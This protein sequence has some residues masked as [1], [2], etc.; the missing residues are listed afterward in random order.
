MGWAWTPPPPPRA[1]LEVLVLRSNQDPGLGYPERPRQ[2]TTT[3]QVIHPLFF[4]VEGDQGNEIQSHNPEGFLGDRA[5][6]QHFWQSSWADLCSAGPA[7]VVVQT[8]TPR[9]ENEI[10]FPRLFRN[11]VTIPGSILE[12]GIMTFRNTLADHR[13][14]NCHHHQNAHHVNAKRGAWLKLKNFKESK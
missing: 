1:R 3:S 6:S 11:A 9:L 8:Q 13:Y 10:I 2:E 7:R 4:E 14:H 12:T 5:V